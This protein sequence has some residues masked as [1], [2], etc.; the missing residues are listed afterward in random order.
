M[1][2]GTVG[3][4]ERTLPLIRTWP[5]GLPISGLLPPL[6]GTPL[7][8]RLKD[9]GRLTRPKHW[10][11]F[12][13]FAMAHTPL[14]MAIPGAHA[15]VLDG[16]NRSYSPGAMTQAVESFDYKRL[17]Y[18]IHTLISRLCFRWLYFPHMG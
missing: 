9:A 3:V 6:P 12:K 13:A 7:Y 2:N 15:E 16:W 1:E 5:A 14:K 18:P 10:L 17:G 8:T 11:E 4:A